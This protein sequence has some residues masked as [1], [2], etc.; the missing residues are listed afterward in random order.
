MTDQEEKVKESI[1]KKFIRLEDIKWF[2]AGIVAVILGTIS[3]VSWAD[4]RIDRKTLPLKQE[5]E[6]VNTTLTKKV[7]DLKS[8][9]DKAE[10]DRKFDSRRQDARWEALLNRMQVK[11]PAPTPDGGR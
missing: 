1:V 8:S 10:E 3:T 9:L 5:I 6:N 7:D 2:A 4:D 11:D